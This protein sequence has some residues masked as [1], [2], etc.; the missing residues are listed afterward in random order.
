[1]LNLLPLLLAKAGAATLTT[2]VV[3][4]GAVSAATIG[5]AGATGVVPVEALLP[6][7]TATVVVEDDTTGDIPVEEPTEGEVSD[8]VDVEAPEDPALEE[9][10]EE[11]ATEDEATDEEA[12][13][14]EPTEEDGGKSA[15]EALDAAQ[16]RAPEQADAGLNRARAAVS[17]ERG[18][19][20]AGTAPGHAARP[21]QPAPEQAEQAKR[22]AQGAERGAPEA[23]RGA[24]AA[25]RA[26]ERQPGAGGG[27]D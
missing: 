5:T 8:E 14:E 3:V 25:D 1:M 10:P 17:G 18:G 11:E 27:R 4:A 20:A 9:A 16:S 6:G 7:D 19:A 13:E 15:L 23:E 26:S 24:G 2:K 21:T 22:P 12:P